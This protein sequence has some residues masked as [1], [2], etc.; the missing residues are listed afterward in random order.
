[1]AVDYT[2]RQKKAYCDRTRWQ[3]EEQKTE[4]LGVE[5]EHQPSGSDIIPGLSIGGLFKS[6]WVLASQ[7]VDGSI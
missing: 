4:T 5:A 1:M 6:S 2:A 3:K 7:G